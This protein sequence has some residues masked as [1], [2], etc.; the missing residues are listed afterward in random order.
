M[1]PWLLAIVGLLIPLIGSGFVVWPFVLVWSAVLGMVW[2][3]G[4]ALV[5]TRPARIVTGLVLLPVLV[6][7]AFE[8]GWYL[9]P[10]VLAWLAI[11]VVDRGPRQLPGGAAVG[12][13]HP[14]G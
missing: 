14:Q 2:L 12:I 10:A 8:G 7:L 3:V 13:D 4:G 11:E 5:P 9:I 6:M 1:V